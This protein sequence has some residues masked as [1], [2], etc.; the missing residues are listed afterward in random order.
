MGHITDACKSK[1]QKVHK[2]ELPESPEFDPLLNIV[3]PYSVAIYNLSAKGKCIEIPVE[4]NG[5]SLLMELD[6]GARVS[7]I[8]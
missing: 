3:D 2:V 4:L 8:S 7:L 1:S 5:N 6:T